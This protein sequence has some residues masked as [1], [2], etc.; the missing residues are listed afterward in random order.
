MA[1]PQVL[2]DLH[3]KN[4]DDSTSKYGDEQYRAAPSLPDMQFMNKEF[5]T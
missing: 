4:E 5:E 3:E 2:L 1:P